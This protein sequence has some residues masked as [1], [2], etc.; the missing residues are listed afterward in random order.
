MRSLGNTGVPGGRS[1]LTCRGQAK[2]FTWTL[3]ASSTMEAFTWV[4][5]KN[6]ISLYSGFILRDPLCSSSPKHV[7]HQPGILYLS[8]TLAAVLNHQLLTINWPVPQAI[9]PVRQ[10][11][12]Q[13]EMLTISSTEKFPF[14]VLQGYPWVGLPCCARPFVAGTVILCWLSVQSPGLREYPWVRCIGWRRM[15]LW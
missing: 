12:Q 1:R 11:G 15:V 5:I 3:T 9:S 2:L 6:Q 10:G 8:K 4:F 7:C 14:S 13:G